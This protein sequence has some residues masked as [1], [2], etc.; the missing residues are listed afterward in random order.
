MPSGMEITQSKHHGHSHSLDSLLS[1]DM[2]A[3]LI[4]SSRL[5]KLCHEI[6]IMKDPVEYQK[7]PY[8]NATDTEPK[9]TQHVKQIPDKAKIEL[10]FETGV[11]REKK[12]TIT[13][14]SSS[15]MNLYKAT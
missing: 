9:Q 15:Y 13:V 7:M 2:Q 4:T 12:E 3:S 11:R 6:F 14:A 1:Q 8:H 10:K 5:G